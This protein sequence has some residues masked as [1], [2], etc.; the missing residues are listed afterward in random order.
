MK[1]CKTCVLTEKFP[2]ARFDAEGRCNYCLE[3]DSETGREEAAAEYRMKF[4]K[5][6]SEHAGRGQYDV[7]VAF[8]GGKD[9]TYTLDLFRNYFRL[10]VLA[11]TFDH[12]FVS[13]YATRNIRA[14]VE[15]LGVDHIMFSPDFH[16]MR[17]IFRASTVRHAYAKKAIERSS[18][19]CLS[20]MSLARLIL[21]KTAQEK[22]IPFIGFGWSPGQAPLQSSVM[23]NSPHLIMSIQ[24]SLAKLLEGVSAREIPYIMNGSGR[25]GPLM[26]INVHP[27]AFMEYDEH[28]IYRRISD[29]GWSKPADTDPNS[30]NCLMNS[31]ANRVH[32]E[33]YG[34]HP[35]AFEISG[36]VRAGVMRREEGLERLNRPDNEEIIRYVGKKL[37][38]PS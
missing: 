23:R 35:Y 15:A 22:A 26:P 9:S 20:C 7:L 12:G 30:T 3:H 37:E 8:S 21:L 1:T 10:K 34:F 24:R 32:I 14:T 36:L 28:K 33:Q 5:L 2:S 16:L 25:D 13:P 29:L 4:E 19:I 27:L 38:L 17:D 31:Y 6:I 18:T 11:L